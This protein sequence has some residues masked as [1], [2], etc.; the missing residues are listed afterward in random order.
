MPKMFFIS[1]FV[2]LAAVLAACGSSAQPAAPVEVGSSSQ[3]NIKAES[4][5]NPAVV[6]DV[7]LTLTITDGNGAPIEGATVD[8]S[9]DH[10]DMTGMGMSGL[11]T[12]QGEG[13]YSIHANFS[14]S[15][16]WKLTVYVRKAGLD[17][18]EDIE[19]KIQ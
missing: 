14:M 16:N 3:V 11:A 17:Y 1:M 18:K 7:E 8:I 10:T 2:V 4:S 9:A 13:R 12:E 19:F 5:P 6:G 15:G